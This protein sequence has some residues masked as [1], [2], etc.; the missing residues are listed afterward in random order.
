MNFLYPK[1]QDPKDMKSSF[2][3]VVEHVF[4]NFSKSVIV[5]GDIGHFGFKRIWSKKEN[6]TRY[7]NLGILEQ[8]MVGFSA[9]LS[10]AEL[11]PIIHTITPFLIERPYEQI[12][13]DFGLNKLAG[14]F[15]SVGGSHDYSSL[16][17]THHSYND[18]ALF[19]SIPSSYVYSV[20]N[21]EELEFSLNDSIKNNRLSY[22]RMNRNI[23]NIDT[24]SNKNLNLST[25]KIKNGE[26]LTLIV[27]GG[28]IK[29]TIEVTELLELDYSNSVE[30]IIVSRIK[31][32]NIELILSSLNK[33]Q[34]LLVIE[35]HGI[36]GSIYQQILMNI[37]LGKDF[38]HYCLNLDNNILS[39]YGSYEELSSRYG[40]SKKDIRKKIIEILKK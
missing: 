27:S 17:P 32:L 35:D 38:N 6:E 12:K 39:G 24:S 10:K 36:T 8:T 1:K 40:L 37:P 5:I 26:K 30:L 22:I 28:R 13:V 15:I 2:I 20:S 4:E 29:D 21:F 16:G 31:P 11:Y 18:L 33:T 34:N 3:E 25:Y 7:F 14:C 9:G 19:S 23:H